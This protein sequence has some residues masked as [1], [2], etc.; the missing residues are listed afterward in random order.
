MLATTLMNKN[1][2]NVSTLAFK[3]KFTIEER[4]QESSRVLTKYPDRIPVICEK[5]S[6]CKGI[7]DIDKN[8]YLVPCDLTCGQFIYIIRRRLSLPA[9]KGIFLLVD[10]LIPP[11]SEAMSSVYSKHKNKDNFLYITY[12][13][14]NVFGCHY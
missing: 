7:P 8:K 14:E 11:S 5:N 2:T 13:G 6:K 3:K 10:G 1:K 9:E 12:T 4:T